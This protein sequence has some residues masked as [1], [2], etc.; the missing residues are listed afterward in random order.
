MIGIKKRSQ[1]NSLTPD[2]SQLSYLSQ[3]IGCSGYFVFTFDSDDPNVL[4]HGRMFA[5][6]IGINEDPVTGNANG[7]LGAYIARHKLA[8]HDG[9][10]FQFKGK[11]GEAIGR[12][13]IVEVKVMIK[14]DKPVQVQIGGN[15]VI[16]FKT[17]I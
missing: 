3:V 14:N 13:G 2:L 15:A 11:Q 9:S 17:S 6:A 1:L 12:P 5:P 4:S 16:V 8:K 10:Q 7:P